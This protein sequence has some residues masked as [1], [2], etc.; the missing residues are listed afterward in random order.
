MTIETSLPPK[1]IIKS[2][3]FNLLERLQPSGRLQLSPFKV[4][5][6][7]FDSLHSPVPFKIIDHQIDTDN[8]SREELKRF[9]C[10]VGR[11]QKILVMLSDRIIIAKSSEESYSEEK[12][13]NPNPY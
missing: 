8:K 2:T 13:G 3:P 10:L 7:Y 9:W 5:L 1:S 4:L 11:R 12:E 6:S